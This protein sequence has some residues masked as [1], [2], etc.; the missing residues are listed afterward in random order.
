MIAEQIPALTGLNLQEKWQL[1][2]ELWDE[3]D[4]L[5]EQLP[6]DDALLKIVEQRF[7]DYERDSSTSMT[8]DEFKLKFRLP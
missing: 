6:T 4:A 3:V 1:A 8:L 5:Q 7:A 2:V